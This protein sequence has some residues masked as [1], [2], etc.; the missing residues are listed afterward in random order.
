M[1]KSPNDFCNRALLLWLLLFLLLLLLK[2]GAA[3]L[4]VSA[5]L[6]RRNVAELGKL[7]KVRCIRGTGELGVSSA[8]AAAVAADGVAL[9]PSCCFFLAA[10]GEGAGD[11][12]PVFLMGEGA[13][14]KGGWLEERSKRGEGETAGAR[15][16]VC[17]GGGIS[18]ALSSSS[19][20]PPST[21]AKRALAESPN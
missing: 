1:G 4:L 15:G 9:P 13:G 3:P 18:F 8:V 11:L 7:S 6:L 2:V 14:A 5:S 19:P 17:G 12:G 21:L 10:M 20:S 16:A